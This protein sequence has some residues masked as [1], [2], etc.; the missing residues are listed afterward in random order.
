MGSMGLL[1]ADWSVELF[2]ARRKKAKK[3]KLVGLMKE[4]MEN[5]EEM[6]DVVETVDRVAEDG[7]HSNEEKIVSSREKKSSTG[8]AQLDQ[9]NFGSGTKRN[10][11]VTLILYWR[12]LVQMCKSSIDQV[13][14]CVCRSKFSEVI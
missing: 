2:R 13:H 10:L 3:A 4:K 9:A 7:G 6:E 14:K 8:E 11:S 5:M 12:A 1:L